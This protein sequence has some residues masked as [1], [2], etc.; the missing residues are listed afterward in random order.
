MKVE[1]NEKDRIIIGN[2]L[3][4]EKE[5]LSDIVNNYK[6]DKKGK[7]FKYWKNELK[8]IVKALDHFYDDERRSI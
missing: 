6:F 1:L 7:S 3:S 8:N 5:K 4:D 2:L